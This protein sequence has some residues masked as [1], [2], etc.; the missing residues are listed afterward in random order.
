MALIPSGRIVST[1]KNMRNLKEINTSL[2]NLLLFRTLKTAV[3]G[4][5]TEREG[6]TYMKREGQFSV[7]PLYY[8]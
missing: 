6:K 8:I 7:C 4:T 5:F 3:R 2:R 1:D